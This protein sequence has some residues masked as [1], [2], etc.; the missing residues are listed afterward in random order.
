MDKEIIEKI[1][2]DQIYK[3]LLQPAAKQVGNILE[4]TVKVTRFVF[5]GIDYLATKQ[6]RW[7]RYLARVSEKV[8]GADLIEANPQIVGPVLEGLAYCD[9]LSLTT[10]M[11]INLLAKSVDKQTQDEAHP[12]FAKIIQ[13]IS[14]DEAVILY[15]LKKKSYRVDQKW[16]LKGNRIENMRTTFEEFPLD[17]LIYSEHIWMYMEHLNSL[18]VAGTWKTQND[19]P[20][21]VNGIQTGGI[22]KSERKLT[23]FGKLFA[24]ACVPDEFEG[25]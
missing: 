4:N 12:A 23:D 14:H 24:K 20:I 10:E 13:Q 25:I 8:E 16:D 18:T 6:D 19:E 17:K 3:D 22:V 2:T 7:Q 15:L 9:E 5:A 11:F 21:I 1:P